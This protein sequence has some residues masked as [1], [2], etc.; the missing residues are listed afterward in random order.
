MPGALDKPFEPLVDGA[1]MDRLIAALLLLTACATAPAG[2]DLT[3]YPAALVGAYDN[4]AQFAQAPDDLKRPPVAHD[5]DEWIDLQTATFSLV[6]APAL[7]PHVI[8]LEWKGAHGVIS[9]QRLWSF[10]RDGPGVR[11]DFFSLREPARFAGQAANA[12]GFATLTAADVI[13]YGAACG[14]IVTAN[15]A[16]AWNAQID[17]EDCRITAQDGREMGFEARVTVMPTG[18]LYQ[19]AA[20]LPDGGYALRVPGGQPYDFRRRP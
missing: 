13:G 1:A 18:L 17:A 3:A 14:L 10:R 19:E 12:Q 2:D 6:S 5:G 11:M 4:A 16:G 9:R 20:R 7:G 15:G 8:Y